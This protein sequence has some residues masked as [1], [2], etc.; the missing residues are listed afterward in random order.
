MKGIHHRRILSMYWETEQCIAKQ[1][2]E[3]CRTP[4]TKI[5]SK[6][7]LAIEV[8]PCVFMVDKLGHQRETLTEFQTHNLQHLFVLRKTSIDARFPSKLQEYCLV[9]ILYSS[10]FPV[11]FNP[12]CQSFLFIIFESE[13]NKWKKVGGALLSWTSH[14]KE[15][16]ILQKVFLWSNLL[17]ESR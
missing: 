8:V 11:A 1:Y 12:S 3:H 2:G 10:H 14:S 13:Q 5:L 4:F 7:F 17:G 16:P 9:L 6:L 15:R